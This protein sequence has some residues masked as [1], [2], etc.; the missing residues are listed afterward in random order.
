MQ[1]WRLSLRAINFRAK[2]GTVREK[3]K[4]RKIAPISFSWDERLYR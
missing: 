3:V 1:A 2:G 4:R